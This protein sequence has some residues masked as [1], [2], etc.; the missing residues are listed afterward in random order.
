MAKNW[1]RPVSDNLSLKAVAMS[2]PLRLPDP[3]TQHLRALRKSRGL[4]QAQLGALVG[5]KQARIA[6]IEA[7]PGAVSLERLIKVLAALGGTLHLH[8]ADVEAPGEAEPAAPAQAVRSKPPTVPAKKVSAKKA[9][10]GTA[11]AKKS[12]AK[13]TLTKSAAG[14]SGA[15]SQVVDAARIP[16][17]PTRATQPTPQTHV[18]IRPKKGAW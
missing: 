13:K 9:T 12:P 1:S 4:T 17:K 18:V 8:S 15:R 7:N 6:E 2:F 16:R 14:L 3:L 11:L 10:A 5:V